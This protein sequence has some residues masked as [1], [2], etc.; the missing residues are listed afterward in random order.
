MIAIAQ[1]F[2]LWPTCHLFF[3]LQE[4]WST[5]TMVLTIIM[6]VFLPRALEGF[7][8]EHPLSLTA[9]FGDSIVIPPTGIKE[10]YQIQLK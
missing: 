1:L 10:N 5:S 2:C 3:A 8:N 9:L 4:L 6:V 7:A